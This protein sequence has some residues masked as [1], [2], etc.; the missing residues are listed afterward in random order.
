M[1]PHIDY[2]ITDKYIYMFT[3]LMYDWLKSSPQ[4]IELETCF[5]EL[6]R[7]NDVVGVI[8]PTIC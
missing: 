5:R 3:R 4:L 8:L 2:M 6:F 1:M 7:D